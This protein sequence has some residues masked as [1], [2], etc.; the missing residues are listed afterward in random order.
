M[1][2]LALRTGAKPRY[3]TPNPRL[4]A[5]PCTVVHLRSSAK[6]TI[7][8]KYTIQTWR[9]AAQSDLDALKLHLNM[10]TINMVYAL[11]F[12]P[13]V[14]LAHLVSAT[15]EPSHCLCIVSWNRL[16]GPMFCTQRMLH[17]MLSQLVLQ[18]HAKDHARLSLQR[19]FSDLKT[20][21]GH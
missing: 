10:Q 16:K 3:N 4:L 13:Y 8:A 18:Q 15:T 19:L 7:H 5:K 20:A 21:N 2:C 1:H 12:M 6:Y 17:V 11:R 9:S 14:L